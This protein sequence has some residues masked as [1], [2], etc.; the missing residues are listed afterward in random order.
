MIIKK[1]FKVILVS[2]KNQFETFEFKSNFEWV[3]Q[4][5]N[6][7]CIKIGQVGADKLIFLKEN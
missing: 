2:T 4:L 3:K 5:N 6:V 1:F 7:R